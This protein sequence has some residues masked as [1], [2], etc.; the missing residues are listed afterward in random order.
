MFNES[1]EIRKHLIFLRITSFKML[2]ISLIRKAS[3]RLKATKKTEVQK[4]IIFHI[5]EC[6]ISNLLMVYLLILF[7]KNVH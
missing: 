1:S 3:L 2:G 6:F 4:N 5:V 7:N